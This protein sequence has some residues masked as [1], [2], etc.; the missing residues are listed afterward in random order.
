[1][2]QEDKH[3]SHKR[4]TKEGLQSRDIAPHGIY[5]SRFTK[6]APQCKAVGTSSL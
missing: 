5:L 1:M 4:T 6:V 3:K 2:P